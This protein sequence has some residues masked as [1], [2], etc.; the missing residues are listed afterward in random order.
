MRLR[1]GAG[2]STG[3]VRERNEDVYMVR[4]ARGLFLVCDGMGGAPAGEVASQIAA[5]MIVSELDGLSLTAA[6]CGASDTGYRAQTHQLATAV[7]RSNQ[8]I[9]EQGRSDPRQAEMGTTMVGVW[10]AGQTASV[11]HVGD[12]RAYLW[13]NGSLEPLTRDHSLGEAILDEGLAPDVSALSEEE[14]SSLIR[15][16]GGEADVDVELKEVALRGG[17]YLLLCSDGLTRM[18]PERTLADAIAR[19]RE[20]Q[21]ICDD[22][23]ELANANGGADNITVVVVEVGG[24]WWRRL[25]SR[26]TR[27]ATGGHDGKADRQVRESRPQ[28]ISARAGHHHR[29]APAQ[30]GDD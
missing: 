11:A 29:P 18:V 7:R 20:P 26:W 24:S 27:D 9:H 12:S 13:R 25:A 6:S 21:R 19:L 8:V 2:T 16:L 28:G 3:R 5:S 17:D 14:R 22:L 10:I 30:R 1:V 15:V 4:A 23:I